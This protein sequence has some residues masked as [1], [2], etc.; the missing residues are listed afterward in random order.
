[1]RLAV[2]LIVIMY[3]LL[4]SVWEQSGQPFTQAGIQAV[5]LIDDNGTTAMYSMQYVDPLED[6]IH[7]VFPIPPGAASV[8]STS[9]YL[10]TFIGFATEPEIEPPHRFRMDCELSPRLVFGDGTV[11]RPIYVLPSTSQFEILDSAEAAR[12]FIA[13]ADLSLTADSIEALSAYEQQGYTFAALTVYPDL[14]AP[15]PD[16]FWNSINVHVTPTIVVEYPGSEPILPLAIRSAQTAAHLDNFDQPDILPV[17]VYLF[18]DTAYAP[19]NTSIL[20]AD[21]SDIARG[22][23][24]LENTMRLYAGDPIFFDELD[25]NYYAYLLREIGGLVQPAFVAEFADA[26]P[27]PAHRRQSPAAE[28]AI[29]QLEQIASDY[30]FLTRWRTFL[31]TDEPVPDVTFAPSED[32]PSGRLSL[33]S[34]VDDAWFYGCTSRRLSD[35]ELDSR[36][37][38]GRTR[39]ND[40]RLSVAHPEHWVMSR[41]EETGDTFTVAFAP[42]AIAAGTTGLESLGYPVLFIQRV[43]QSGG[44]ADIY[45]RLQNGEPPLWDAPE[46]CLSRA[47]YQ[48]SPNAVPVADFIVDQPLRSIRL[49]VFTTPDDCESNLLLYTDLLA[50][51]ASFQYFLSGELRHTLF[52]GDLIHL[53]ALGY[54]EGWIESIVDGMRLMSPDAQPYQSGPAIR[55]ISRRTAESEFSTTR[56]NG[57]EIVPFENDTR[58]GYLLGTFDQFVPLV[59]FSAPRTVFEAHASLLALMAETAWVVGPPTAN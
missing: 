42:E 25:P 4:G 24:Q 33:S 3:G 28:R 35:S 49:A 38:R 46:A 59:E 37:P 55:L 26:P 50:Y 15:Q 23:N 27:V 19:A 14:T 9:S 36:L 54:P 40:I 48:P 18:A 41:L 57:G 31:T 56:L 16:G 2:I 32:V 39:I 29:Q 8:T 13:K 53:T 51:A 30:R 58:S 6:E 21:L 22:T 5:F 47:F 17:N 10:T 7:W 20:S 43:E 34:F 52:V 44:D 45:P 12:R 1:M 11:P